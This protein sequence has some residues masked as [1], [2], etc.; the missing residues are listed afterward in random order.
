MHGS[1]NQAKTAARRTPA[2]KVIQAIVWGWGRLPGL[3]GG[4]EQRP[5][6]HEQGL[7]GRGRRPLRHLV[8]ALMDCPS[9]TKG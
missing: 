8:V 6:N 4:F 5:L 7:S 9:P 1:P 2:V 3:R